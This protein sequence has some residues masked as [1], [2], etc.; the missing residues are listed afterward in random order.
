MFYDMWNPN[1]EMMYLQNTLPN[2]YP[3]YQ[4]PIHPYRDE[5]QRRREIALSPYAATRTDLGDGFMSYKWEGELIN[6]NEYLTAYMEVPGMKVIS[7]GW[8]ISDFSTAYA[9]ES[10]PS[11]P[12]QWVITVFNGR[13]GSPSPRK[14][15]FHLIAKS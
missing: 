11:R 14:V 1:Y 12:E 13:S 15:S 3:E 7:G 2:V 10:Y 9:I 6:H 4:F 8:Y 5:R